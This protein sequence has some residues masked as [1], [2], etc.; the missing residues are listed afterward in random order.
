ML[1]FDMEEAPQGFWEPSPVTVRRITDPKELAAVTKIESE[2]WGE[3]YDDLE[4][5]WQRT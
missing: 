5:S 1:A 2:V 3:P 4:A